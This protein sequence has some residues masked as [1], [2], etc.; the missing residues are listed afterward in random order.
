MALLPK[1]MLPAS[2]ACEEKRILQ[3]DG[4]VLA[5]RGE[6]VLA[7]VDTVEEDLA[8]CDVVEAHHQAGERRL[9]RAGVTDDCHRLSR[10]DG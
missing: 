10:L 6:I 8:G 4:E 2:V 1:R 5:E 7:Q 3:D 9:A